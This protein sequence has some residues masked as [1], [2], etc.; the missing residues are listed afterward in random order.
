MAL[1]QEER[2]SISEKLVGIPKENETAEK[3]IGDI[4]KAKAEAEAKDLTNKSLG[5]SKTPLINNYQKEIGFIDGNVRTELVEQD[6]L[7]GAQKKFRNNFFPNDINTPLPS[8][9]D[10]VWKNFQSFG[11]SRAIGKKYEEDFDSQDS[12][13]SKL[14]SLLADIAT[15][16]GFSD[17]TRVTGESCD[18]NP[19]PPPPDLI[20][21]DDAIQDLMTSI[22]ADVDAFEAILNSEKANIVSDDSDAGRQAENDT[23]LDDI[24]N[25]ILPAITTWEALVDF[26]PQGG[27]TCAVFDA[28]DIGPLADTKFKPTQLTA[29]KA[30]IQARQTFV[31]TRSAQVL[32][33]L[34]GVVQ[35]PDGTITGTTGFYGDRFRFVELR[36]NIM[37]GT[38]SLVQGLDKGVEAQGQVASS[39]ENASAAL[40]SVVKASPLLAP[41]NGTREVQVAAPSLFSVKD[42]VY[43]IAK[44]KD[45]IRSSITSIQGNKIILADSVTAG[46][47]VEASGRLYKD[48]S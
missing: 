41:T 39:N 30:A 45:E 22:K 15:V 36:L 27:T 24:N 35:S 34:G 46:Y 25:N 26:D 18:A 16:E 11:L 12:E 29:F 9:A 44:G 10:G 2:I 7:D 4:E 5:E 19:T 6:I 48:I 20:E 3:L 47:K 21:D 1:T 33:N 8:I 38:L 23:A 28:I 17:V 42:I 37:T 13:N 31:A 43:V 32:A 14:T 40:G